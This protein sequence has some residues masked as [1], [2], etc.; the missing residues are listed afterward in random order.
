MRELQSIE[1]RQLTLHQVNTTAANKQQSSSSLAFNRQKLSH[2]LMDQSSHKTLFADDLRNILIG[3]FGEAPYLQAWQN[4]DSRISAKLPLELCTHQIL[5][6]ILI[7]MTFHISTQQAKSEINK[8]FDRG[9]LETF[10]IKLSEIILDEELPSDL[11]PEVE[12][13]ELENEITVSQ[14]II[15]GSKQ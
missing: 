8:V 2:C 15:N 7:P 10:L 4:I 9:Q 14:Y 11:F 5:T 6:N 12:P 1:Q 13:T 3:N